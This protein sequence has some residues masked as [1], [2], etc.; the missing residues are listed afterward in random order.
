MTFGTHLHRGLAALCTTLGTATI[1]AGPAGTAA[2]ADTAAETH[3]R[4][5][6]ASVAIRDALAE[7][8]RVP[9]A[10]PAA[11]AVVVHGDA[12]P[13]MFVEGVARAGRPERVDHSSQF[14]IA[15]QTKSFMALLGA[16]LDERGVLP[17]DTTLA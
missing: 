14:Y 10:F 6:T 16:H 9:G 5:Q 17:L 3:Q 13:L 8:Q 15:S 11:M 1:A 2:A 4:V 7:V 12:T